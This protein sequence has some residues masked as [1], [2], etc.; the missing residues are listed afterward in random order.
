MICDFAE[1]YHIYDYQTL[2]VGYVATLL[3]GL[4]EDSRTMMK[5]T[6]KKQKQNTI[7]LAV[8]ADRLSTLVWFQT[9]DG[10]KN[11]NRPRSITD[12]LLGINVEENEKPLVFN[13]EK[14][15]NEALAK[16]ERKENG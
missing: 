6:G 4:G 10:Y 14:E 3:S 9:K 8:I 1:I 2:S 13:S 5:L 11:K 15:L 12:I 16:F 7:L